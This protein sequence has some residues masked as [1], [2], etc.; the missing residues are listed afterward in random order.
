MGAIIVVP[1]SK[2]KIRRIVVVFVDNMGIYSNGIN[3][4]SNMQIILDTYRKLYKT[5]GGSI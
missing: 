2:I 3:A 1:R 5:I 4:Q